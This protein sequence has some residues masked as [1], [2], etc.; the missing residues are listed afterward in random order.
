MADVVLAEI[1]TVKNKSDMLVSVAPSF[2]QHE[3]E[4]GN[5]YDTARIRFIEKRFFIIAIKSYGI[6]D[7]W[8][9]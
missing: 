8:F 9:L 5:I 3:L 1:S 6:V 7:D 2:F 4:L